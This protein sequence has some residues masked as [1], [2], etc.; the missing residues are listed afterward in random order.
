[1]IVYGDRERTVALDSELT[2]L[3]MRMEGARSR[4]SFDRHAALAALAIDVGSVVQGLLD[5]EFVRDGVD[6]LTACQRACAQASSSAAR[7]FVHCLSGREPRWEELALALQ[8]LRTFAAHGTLALRDPEGYA[9]YALYPE[10]YIHAARQL[11]LDRACD[12]QV[13]GI[14]SIGCS[15]APLVAAALGSARDACTVRPTGHPFARELRIGAELEA[16]LLRARSKTVFAVVDE[17]PGMSGSSFDAVL[18]YLTAREVG[19]EQIVLFPSHPGQPGPVCSAPARERYLQ[20]ERALVTFDSYFDGTS[21]RRTLSRWFERELER[22][23]RA[24]E[25]LSAGR[26][27]AHRAFDPGGLPASYAREERRKYLLT[28]DQGAWLMKYTGL[29]GSAPM[30]SERARILSEAGFTP[31]WLG[32]RHGFTLTQFEQAAQP[33]E[34]VERQCVIER[35]AAYL[36]FL[37]KTFPRAA[38]CGAGPSSLAELIVHNAGELLGS[39][40]ALVAASLREQVP[41]LCET[42]RVTATDNKLEAYEWLCTSDGRLL[43]CDA[44][45]HCAGHDCIGCQ[46][47][48]WDLAGACVELAL[49]PSELE[50]VQ[51]QLWDGAR[52]RANHAKLRFYRLAYAA[53]RAGRAHYGVD[54][55]RGWAEDDA[56]RVELERLRYTHELQTLLA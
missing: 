47:P 32:A 31:R 48:A 37:T 19:R 42:H 33:L 1:M 53:F 3:V 10:L 55:L 7:A 2:S 41:G 13:I 29:G 6:D 49:T 5:R 35:L 22:P 17:G 38:S 56:Q 15:L 27:R 23:I 18:R 44:E 9:F 25:D 28:N 46:D 14:R 52:Y 39:E 45:D 24:C 4:A 21:P 8:Q 34:H 26:W 12:V 50:Q 54:S 51:R 20:T 16:A 36:T 11:Q 40:H 30:L 43:K